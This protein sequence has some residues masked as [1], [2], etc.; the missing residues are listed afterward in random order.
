[1]RKDLVSRLGTRGVEGRYSHHLLLVFI[2]HPFSAHLTSERAILILQKKIELAIFK[3]S[4][5]NRPLEL[6]SEDE[7]PQAHKDMP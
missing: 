1:M 3:N 4:N 2:R 6:P 7:A 5:P